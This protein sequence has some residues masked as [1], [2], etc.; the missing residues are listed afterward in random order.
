MVRML[1]D[2]S[3][4]GASQSRIL[5]QAARLPEHASVRLARD[6]GKVDG[7]LVIGSEAFEAQ[8]WE[9]SARAASPGDGLITC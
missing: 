8:L 4:M 7:A 2:A 1:R 5:W 9:S 3:N 6:G